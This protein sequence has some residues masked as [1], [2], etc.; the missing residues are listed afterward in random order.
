M[1]RIKTALCAGAASLLLLL[2]LAA[3]RFL[4]L[5]PAQ[6][7]A[8]ESGPAPVGR[9]QASCAQVQDGEIKCMVLDTTDGSVQT[10]YRFD[11]DDQCE[12][13]D[14]LNFLFWCR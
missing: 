3:S 8:A 10:V 14:D 2:C 11:N 7:R 9:Y 4:L 12:K 5:P 13:K 6:A 1:K